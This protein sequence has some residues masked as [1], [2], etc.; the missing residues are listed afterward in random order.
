MMRTPF[1][2]GFPYMPISISH[3]CSFVSGSRCLRFDRYGTAREEPSYLKNYSLLPVV[4]SAAN[5]SPGA[6]FWPLEPLAPAQMHYLVREAYLRG[7]RFFVVQEEEIAFVEAALT[8]QERVGRELMVVTNRRSAFNDTVASWRGLLQMPI[9]AIAGSVGKSTTK[10]MLASI[11]VND[12]VTIFTST[13]SQDSLEGIA[14]NILSVTKQASIAVFE[15]GTRA[16]GMLREM[17]AL[18]RPSFGIITSVDADYLPAFGS[19]EAVADEMLTLFADFSPSQIGII[20][21]DYLHL[22]RRTYSI[23]IVRYGLEGKKNVVT[24]ECSIEQQGGELVTRMQLSLFDRV[25]VVTLPGTHRGLV[26]A[27]LAASAAAYFL[28]APFDVILAGLA[29]YKIA[30]GRFEVV[31]L[32]A[33]KGVVINDCNS[34]NPASL[35]GALLAFHSMSEGTRKIAVLGEMEHLGERSVFWHRQIGRDLMQARSIQHLVLVGSMTREV[36][37]TAPATMRITHVETWQEAEAALKPL[38]LATDN[39]VLIKGTS[40][41]SPLVSHLLAGE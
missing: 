1:T 27:A 30:K 24:A 33:G 29:A 12:G 22:N 17:A 2:S 7:A 8:P 3:I 6:T 20:C 14:L 36:A 19:I 37:K 25:G 21:A 15:L 39:A 13:E 9:V 32:P 16:R 5:A 23:P 41:F 26:Y 18:L 35:R 40:T 4:I 38:L 11:F 10:E 31:P 28:H 34:T